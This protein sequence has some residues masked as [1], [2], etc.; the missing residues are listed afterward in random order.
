V[1]QID[2]S[3]PPPNH[4]Y[5][6]SI[7][8]EETKGERGVRLFKDLALFIVAIGFVALIVWLCY[9]TLT[10]SSTTPEEKRWAMSILTGA[11][12][13]IIGYLVKK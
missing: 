12:G 3:K 11:A 10:S 5:S 9:S 7:E 13:G 4:K 6:V 8:R 2:L 1:S